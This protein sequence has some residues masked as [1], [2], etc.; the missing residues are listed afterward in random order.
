M[1]LCM[2]VKKNIAPP[3]KLII[4]ACHESPSSS[5]VRASDR[6][7]EGHGFYSCRGLRF[8][9]CPMLATYS[10]FSYY[11]YYL[12]ERYKNTKDW[13]SEQT[14]G[15]QR[16]SVFCEEIVLGCRDVVTI[17]HAAVARTSTATSTASKSEN[18][19]LSV[20]QET[21]PET[22]TDHKKKHKRAKAKD[23]D[24]ERDLM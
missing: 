8:F 2:Y 4:Y 11:F 21:S 24:E 22:R 17:R 16:Q 9:L 10:I 18:T 13:K 23:S 7:T 12:F 20:G 15:H 1:Y 6:C 19:E 3:P 5:V 14:G